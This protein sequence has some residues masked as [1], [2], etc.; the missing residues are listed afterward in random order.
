M[1]SHYMLTRERLRLTAGSLTVLVAL[2]HLAHPTLG[3]RGL[4]I[5]TLAGTPLIDP[6]PLAFTFSGLVVLAGVL[7]VRAGVIPRRPAYLAGSIVMA[8][9]LLGYVAWHMTGHGGFWP[10]L[11]PRT[12]LGNPIEILLVHLLN[13]SW[14]LIS[15]LAELAALVLWV[16]LFRV[17]RS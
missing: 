2:L 17:D 12:H 5:Y 7:S 15:K 13:D 14:E 10:T 8:T 6:R 1:G 3:V 16:Y 11:E 4:Y 9:F